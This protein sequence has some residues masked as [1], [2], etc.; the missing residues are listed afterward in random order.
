[1]TSKKQSNAHEPMTQHK[2]FMALLSPLTPG[3]IFFVVV[4][5]FPK[6]KRHW[7]PIRRHSFQFQVEHIPALWPWA[8]NLTSINLF[9]HL[10]GKTRVVIRIKR[11][12]NEGAINN[13][14]IYKGIDYF[15]NHLQ[16]QVIPIL[17]QK[18]KENEY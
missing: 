9:Y 1:M 12:K 13:K 7:R 8:T 16:V 10:K 5:Q 3:K 18:K 14:A 17:W 4:F 2:S 6:R 11:Y 15:L